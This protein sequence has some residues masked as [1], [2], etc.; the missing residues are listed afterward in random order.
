MVVTIARQSLVERKGAGR[1][2]EVAVDL[3][4]YLSLLRSR[5]LAIFL[6]VTRQ[7]SLNGEV[8]GHA[9]EP[10]LR[11]SLPPKIRQSHCAPKSQ[12]SQ[13]ITKSASPLS[14]PSFSCQRFIRND[15]AR[16][17]ANRGAGDPQCQENEDEG[18]Q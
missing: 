14:D 6:I 15:D 9:L 5:V 2:V 4:G 13:N 17:T 18:Q 11:T 3:D 1:I 8:K 7:C 12:Q 10:F 16:T